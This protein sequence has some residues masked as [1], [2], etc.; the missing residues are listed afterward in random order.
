MNPG[1][2]IRPIPAEQTRGL[3]QAILRPHQTVQAQ[4]YA[5][6]D[7]PD[8]WH[9]GAFRGDELVGIATIFPAS[10]PGDHNPRAWRLRGMATIASMRRQGVGRAL[11]EFCV[12]HIRAHHGDELWCN[13]RT[14]AREFYETLGFSA[15]GDEFD[16]PDSGAHF[17]FRRR[18]E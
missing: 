1:I 5:A 12:A 15:V 9:A 6:D 7:A 17:V 2:E 18:I 8:T 11:I 13:G 3:R 16:T 14:S 10:A 4:V